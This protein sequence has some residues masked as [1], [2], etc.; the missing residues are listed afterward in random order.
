ML[1]PTTKSCDKALND[2]R[3]FRRRKGA[4]AVE[5]AIISPILVLLLFSGIEFGRTF[6]AIQAS[7]EAVRAGCR[8]AILDGATASEVEDAVASILDPA[9]ISTYTVTT[10]P[11]TLGSSDQWDPITVSTTIDLADVSW[12]GAP[13]FFSNTSYTASCT[14]PNEALRAPAA[15]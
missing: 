11:A 15:P 9:G 13:L 3:R 6:M 2:R 1:K 10:D 4:T 12:I 14:L 8:V 7:D 5:F